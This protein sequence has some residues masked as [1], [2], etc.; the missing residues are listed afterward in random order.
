MSIGRV[1]G[2]FLERIQ[3]QARLAAGAAAVVDD[4]GARARERGDLGAAGTQEGDLDARDVVL[5]HLED[6]LEQ[7]RAALVI[8]EAAGQPLRRLR[9]AGEHGLPEIVRRRREVMELHGHGPAFL[10]SSPAQ[11]QGPFCVQIEEAAVFGTHG[12]SAES[13]LPLWERDRVRGLAPAGADGPSVASASEVWIVHVALHILRNRTAPAR[14]ALPREVPS[15]CPSPT[16]GEGTLMTALRRLDA[17][18]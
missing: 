15:P 4:V 17:A 12:G 2:R 7:V 10:A 16:R 5:G 18:D 11:G 9:E 6:G 14:F 1:D 8:D 13:L 3:Q